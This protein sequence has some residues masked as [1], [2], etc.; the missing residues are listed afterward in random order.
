MHLPIGTRIKIVGYDPD[1]NGETG[2]VFA[3]DGEYYLI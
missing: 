2:A 3:R 1:F